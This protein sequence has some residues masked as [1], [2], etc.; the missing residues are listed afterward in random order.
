MRELDKVLDSNEKVLWEGKPQFK[1][2]VFGGLSIC[3]GIV[4]FIIIFLIPFVAFWA[5]F[6]AQPEVKTDSAISTILN[7]WIFNISYVFFIIIL[8]PVIFG[9]I[10]LLLS[11]GKVYYAI[12]DKRVI[13]QQGVIGRDFKIVD[14]DQISGA[15]VD[16]GLFDKM[17]GKESGTIKIYSPGHSVA[18]KRGPVSIPYFLQN[19][20][21]PYEVFKFFKKTSFDVRTDIQYPNELRP[22]TNPGYNSKYKP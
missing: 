7:L 19:I 21:N 10:Y 18:T 17:F 6:N 5:F 15:E 12:T 2:Y 16:I 11:Y 3:V 14:F 13:L 9:S 4:V 1:P 22:A 8:L 20:D